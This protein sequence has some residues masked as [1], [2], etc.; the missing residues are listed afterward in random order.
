MDLILL[1]LYMGFK[2]MQ[3]PLHQ[4]TLSWHKQQVFRRFF[5]NVGDFGVLQGVSVL[6]DHHMLWKNVV[7]ANVKF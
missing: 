2:K 3:Y 1:T 6:N 4:A 7:F 5:A